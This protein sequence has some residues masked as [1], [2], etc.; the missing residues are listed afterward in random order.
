VD[1]YLIRHADAVS[2]GE[3]N[4]TVDEERPLSDVGEA[5][6][7]TL[8]AGLQ[9]QGIRI[10]LVLTSPLL[11]ARQ[12]AEG[13][14]RQWTLP[15]PGIQ[16]CAALAPGGR[17]K[18]LARLLRDF[19]GKSVAL[20]GHMPDLAEHAAWLVGS[21]KTQL[22]F[23]KAGVAYIAIADQPGKRSGTLVWLVTPEWMEK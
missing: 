6:A 1:L 12:T 20:V 13:M 14:L 17:P 5:Q 21:K 22:D 9:R 18:K 23:A 7:R 15:T 19:E 2:V 8:A 3:A 4:V 11:R 10:D 16:E